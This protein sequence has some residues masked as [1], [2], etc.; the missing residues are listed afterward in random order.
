MFLPLDLGKIFLS[1]IAVSKGKDEVWMSLLVAEPTSPGQISK[2]LLIHH[3][4][5]NSKE[6]GLKL[7]TRA[8]PL[9]YLSL[10]LGLLIEHLSK[11]ENSLQK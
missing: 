9:L 4:Q 5:H 3:L 10:S 6:G 1:G 11:A 8:M 7:P 2:V